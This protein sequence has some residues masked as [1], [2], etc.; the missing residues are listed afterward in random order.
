[1]QYFSNSPCS[2]MALLLLFTG[3]LH[4]HQSTNMQ[5]CCCFS[6]LK[7][8]F[9]LP[10]F[11][12]SLPFSVFLCSS[13]QQNSF[14]ALSELADFN[15][16]SYILSEKALFKLWESSNIHRS[17]RQVKTLTFFYLATMLLSHNKTD[18]L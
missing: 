13:L 5:M 12:I 1:M 6:H 4:S 3:S 18:S 8:F 11:S 7:E 2:F 10:H 17:R 15:F 14:K 9:F 16:S